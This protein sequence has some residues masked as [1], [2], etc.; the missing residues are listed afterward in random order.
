M[1]KHSLN[2]PSNWLNQILSEKRPECCTLNQYLHEF[3]VDTEVFPG[4]KFISY[5]V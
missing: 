2:E 3:S 1:S 4:H 5:E